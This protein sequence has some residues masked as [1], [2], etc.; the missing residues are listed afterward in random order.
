MRK[1]NIYCPIR[2]GKCKKNCVFSI[3]E[4]PF[5]QLVLSIINRDKNIDFKKQI[6]NEIKNKME[7][8]RL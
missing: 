5:C 6:I 7:D 1:L 4:P 2:K 8:F 3:N